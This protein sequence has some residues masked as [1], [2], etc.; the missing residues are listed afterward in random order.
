M[1]IYVEEA[2]NSF[3]IAVIGLMV[4]GLA[5]MGKVGLVWELT[6]TRFTM[7][8]ANVSL[9]PKLRFKKLLKK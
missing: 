1:Q 5:A 8:I 2:V 3:V 9:I 6:I 4:I 7:E